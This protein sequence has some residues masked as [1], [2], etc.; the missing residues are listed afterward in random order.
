MR[1]VQ[2]K[3]AKASVFAIYG[4]HLHQATVNAGA[5]ARGVNLRFLGV[6]KNVVK[7]R[8][9]ERWMQTLDKTGREED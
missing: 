8:G 1:A 7:E 2:L 4:M 5:V 9:E 3:S 6:G